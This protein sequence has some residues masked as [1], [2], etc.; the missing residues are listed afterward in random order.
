MLR[1]KLRGEIG[2]GCRE[3]HEGRVNLRLGARVGRN[4][5]YSGEPPP[6]TASGMQVELDWDDGALVVDLL[7]SGQD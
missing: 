2:S 7:R 5:T 6:G 3:S 1:L 4:F